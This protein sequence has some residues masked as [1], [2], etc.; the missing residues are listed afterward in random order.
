MIW[1]RMLKG[2]INW[3]RIP[4]IATSIV[5]RTAT[6]IGNR[7]WPIAAGI[8]GIETESAR[9]TKMLTRLAERGT[10]VRLVYSDADPGRDELARHFGPSGRRLQMPNVGVAVIGNA[11]HDITSQAARAQYLELLLEHL[12]CAASARRVGASD[13]R[14]AAVAEAA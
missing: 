12:G 7:V 5:C 10:R 1:R 2:D 6:R 11:D 8:V 9:V 3:P 4:G 13:A 14:T